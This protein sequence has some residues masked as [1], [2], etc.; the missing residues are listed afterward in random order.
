MSIRIKLAMTICLAL[1]LQCALPALAQGNMEQEILVLINKY[2]KKKHLAPL[3]ENNLVTAQAEKHSRG[4]ANGNVAFGHGGF[5]SRLRLL[6]KQLPGSNAGA[7]NVAYGSRT[8][9]AVVEMWL[10]SPGHKKNIQG[11]YNLTGIGVAKSRDGT[12]FYTQIFIRQR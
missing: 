4:M 10:N 11:N 8:A 7:E 3:K 5:D 2:R 9:E 12:L 1:C 6:M